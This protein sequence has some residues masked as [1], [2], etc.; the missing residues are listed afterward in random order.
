VGIVAAVFALVA[1]HAP[2]S[3]DALQAGGPFRIVRSFPVS[4]AAWAMKVGDLYL[5]AAERSVL[6]YRKTGPGVADYAEVNRILPGL[7][8]RIENC[9]VVGDFLYVPATAQGLLAY[10]LAEL[11]RSGVESATRRTVARRIGSISVVAGRAYAA[12]RDGGLGVFD[13][14]SLTLLGEGLLDTK[15]FGLSAAEHGVVYTSAITSYGELLVV[16]ARDPSALKIA[17]RVTNPDYPTMLRYPA[18]VVGDTLYFPEGNGGVGVYDI[19]N[20]LAPALRFR[21]GAVGASPARGPRARPGQVRA[22][23]VGGE[24]GYPVSDRAVKAV[25]IRAD[26][27]EEIGSISTCDLSGGGLLD[28]Q[29]VFVRAGVAAIPTTMGGVRFIDVAD[30][31]SPAPLLTVDLPSRIEGLAKVQ[32]MVYA[33]SDLDGIWQIDWEAA[34]GPHAARRIP[35]KGLSEDLVH[36]GRY[37]Y[38]ANG[39]GLAVIDVSDEADPHEVSYW[40]F[41]YTAAPDVKEGWVEGVELAGDALYAAV[42]PAGL[43]TFDL[44]APARPR[45]LTVCRTGTSPWGHDISVDPARHLLAFSGAGRVVLMDVEDPANPRLLAD[46]DAPQGKVTQGSTFSPD[47]AHLVVCQAGVFS[48]FDVVDSR[49]PKLLKTSEGCGSEGALFYQG[50][51]LVSGRG[52]GVSV[53]RIGKTPADLTRVQTL[54]RFPY[55]SKFFVEGDR[56]FTNSEG[57]DELLLTAP[58]GGD[59]TGA[60]TP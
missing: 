27:M 11:G 23:A 40:D 3:A 44:T 7:D 12:Y 25:R 30:P 41:P 6:V 46:I 16:D 17:G 48:V 52:A 31:S 55:N 56:V 29:G 4:E 9:A 45:Q 49:S 53:W 28:P 60:P 10:R 57:I 18:P 51:L 1:V 34:G 36:H 54:P 15:L 37:L 50:Y 38:V 20:P 13:A 47:G 2:L 33:T 5:V 35:L 59:P 22:F 8:G 21:Y 24:T 14:A 39:V 42:G 43:A 32:R 58:P 26:S 19:T